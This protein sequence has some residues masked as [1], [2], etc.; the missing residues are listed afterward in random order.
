MMDISEDDRE[1][2][3]DSEETWGIFCLFDNQLEIRGTRD[4][5]ED[6]EM[7]E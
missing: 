4:F 3:E 1:E 5:N 6:N 7:Q 2:T